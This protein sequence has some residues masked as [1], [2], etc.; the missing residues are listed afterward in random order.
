MA[1]SQ[2]TG[3]RFRAVDQPASVTADQ[4]KEASI[5]ELNVSL[6]HAGERIILISYLS[7]TVQ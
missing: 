3:V 2:N 1:L 4:V 5:Y 6:A 7:V